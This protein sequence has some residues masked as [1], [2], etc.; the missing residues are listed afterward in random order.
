MKVILA[1]ASPRRKELLATLLD[2]FEICP[3]GAEEIC[4][5]N[6]SPAYVAQN[7][8]IL[9]AKDVSLRH[10]DA[11]VI[12]SDT[13]VDVDGEILGKPTDTED[14]KR[15]LRLLS[16]RSHLVHTG[17]A[18]V[19]ADTVEQ[20]VQSCRVTFAPMT[21]E[22]IAS[23]VFTGEPMDKAGAYAIQGIGA[24]FVSEIQGDFY[25]VMGLPVAKLYALLKRQ[26]VLS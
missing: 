13:V 1:S 3:S 11:L 26:G 9:K 5:E 6:T 23:Y 7:L 25:T 19:T 8:A 16:G 4:E 12:G 17:L 15:M 22:E 21:E 20:L 24:R 14:A 18:V 10:P 2:A